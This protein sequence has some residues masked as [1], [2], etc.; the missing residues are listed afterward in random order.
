MH[1]GAQ[2]EIRAYAQALLD[3]ALDYF[4]AT[5]HEWKQIQEKRSHG[6]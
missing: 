3:L 5:L 2:H 1:P 4:P 6:K